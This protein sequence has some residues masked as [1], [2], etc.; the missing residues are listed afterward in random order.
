MKKISLAMAAMTAAL[1]LG[2]CGGPSTSSSTT[3]TPPATSTTTT[4]P[5]LTKAQL[6]REF[7]VL[8]KPC[9][10][11]IAKLKAYPSSTSETSS[12][13]DGTAS[14]TAACIGT[15]DTKLRGMSF[16]GETATDAD[17]LVAA[18]GVLAADLGKIRS[19][20]MTTWRHDAA[21]EGVIENIV[22]TDL[23][24]PTSS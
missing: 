15:L 19:V 11:L 12:A 4:S 14:K 23:G 18:A 3:A 20:H 22:R 7:L 2:A 8:V 24:L 17:S 9:D 6:A 21:V 13:L 16:T 10:A 1:L 5:R